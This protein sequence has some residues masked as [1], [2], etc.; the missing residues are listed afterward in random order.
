MKKLLLIILLLTGCSKY[1]DL[2]DLTIVKSIGIE[3]NEKYTIYAQIYDDIKKDNEPKTNIIEVNGKTISESFNNLKKIV[4]KNIFLS[5]IDLLI[6]DTNFNDN[7]YQETIDY[8]INN[9]EL[10]N[11]FNTILSSNIKNLLSTTKYDEIENYIKADYNDKNIVNLS[12]RELAN[13]YLERN[14]FMITKINYDKHFEYQTYYYKN[15]HLESVNNEKN[16]T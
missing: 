3:Y 4:N 7:N 16:W 2:K 10:R 1:T 14:S 6:I 15:N 11:D 12:F 8:F 5:H 13:N 9:N